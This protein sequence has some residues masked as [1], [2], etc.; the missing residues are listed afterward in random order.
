MVQKMCK[1]IQMFL[2]S[3]YCYLNYDQKNDFVVDLQNV[4]KWC[5]FSR[6]DHAKVVLKKNF[7]KDVDF[8]VETLLPSLR[9]R[10]FLL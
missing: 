1:K 3:F 9:E 8:I 6:I 4:W 5:G 2:A 7:T 10:F